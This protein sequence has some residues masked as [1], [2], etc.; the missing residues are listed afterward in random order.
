MEYA[1]KILENTYGT[2]NDI[3]FGRGDILI[4]LLILSGGRKII[5][6]DS[7]LEMVKFVKKE[8][9]KRNLKALLFNMNAGNLYDK[10]GKIENI[11]IKAVTH[12]LRNPYKFMKEIMPHIKEQGSFII[13]KE[14][15][16]PEDNLEQIGKYEESKEEQILKKF[17]SAYFNKRK[18]LE[19]EFKPPLM[20]AGDYDD[21]IQFLGENNFSF[22][23]EIST[24]VWKRKLALREILE[25]I[26]LGSFSVFGRKVS[27]SKKNEL[28]RFMEGYCKENSLDIDFPRHYDAQ[29]KA[30]I[31]KKNG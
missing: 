14:Y 29:L 9:K 8:L 18:D 28:F 5:G 17:Y 23:E 30:V 7:S 19:I 4:P 25:A 20:P 1:K 13:G 15:S 12:L 6:T 27:D 26:N 16:Q 24:H 2:I 21:L 22:V 3:G 10:F 11:H 31:M